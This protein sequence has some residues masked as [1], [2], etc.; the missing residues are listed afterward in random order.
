MPL[1]AQMKYT[2]L[3]LMNMDNNKTLKIQ[4]KWSRAF[5]PNKTEV[6]KN[7]DGSA[8]W[9]YLWNEGIFSNTSDYFI[10]LVYVL[11][12]NKKAGR[13]IITPHT[14]AIDT[15]GLQSLIKK[16]KKSG[17]TDKYNFKIRVNPIKKNA[18]EF[19]DTEFDMTQYLDQKG[20]DNMNK[21]LK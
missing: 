18:F 3:I 6:T 9:F 17:K 21:E 10:F 4:I 1:N 7:W 14:L 5:E 20:F 19:A 11:E 2:D 16:H 12:E 15:K 13:R 8:G